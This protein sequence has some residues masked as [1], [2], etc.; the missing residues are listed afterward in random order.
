MVFYSNDYYR[1]TIALPATF[2]AN[3]I[4]RLLF[5]VQ[6]QDAAGVLR[7]YIWAGVFVFLGVAWSKW[8]L[9][10]NQQ[11]LITISHVSGAILNIVFNYLFIPKFSI[12]GAAYATILSY[13]LSELIAF[14]LYKPK[15]TFLL[16]LNIILIR[17]KHVG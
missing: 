12:L 8:I 2:L 6:Y 15:I 5:G 11:K 13:F 4:V 16:I 14:S 17:R 1:F 10:E 3:D 7:I 9:V